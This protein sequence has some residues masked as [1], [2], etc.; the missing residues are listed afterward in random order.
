MKVCKRGA[1][2]LQIMHGGFVRPCEFMVS[3]DE[4]CNF[5]SLLESDLYEI[6]HGKP[7]EEL[8]E[9]I[10]NGKNFQYCRKD[11]CRNLASG[12][13]DFMTE[14]DSIPEY[15]WEL[16]LAYDTT[17]NY[18]CTSCIFHKYPR[19]NA[20]VLH[21]IEEKVRKALPYVKRLIA[22]GCGEVFASKSMMNLLAEWEPISPPE[23]CC[24][25]LQTNGSLFN[26]E[27]WKKI[28][29]IG[30]FYLDVEITIHSFHEKTYQ[31][32][33][34]TKLPIQNLIDNLHFV[35]KLRRE[36]IINRLEL[37]TVVQEQNFRE[38]P[39]FVRRC[40]DEFE[41]DLVR[42]RGF[43]PWGA[44]DKNVEWFFNVRNPKHPYYEEYLEVMR[45]PIFEHPKVLNWM[46]HSQSL[47]GEIPAKAN[48]DILRK[49][50]LAEHP[51]EKVKNYLKER[52]QQGVVIYGLC[53][54]ADIVANVFECAGIEV[55]GIMDKYTPRDSWRNKKIQRPTREVLQAMSDII[56]IAIANKAE[57]VEQDL[58]REGFKGDILKLE[59]LL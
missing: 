47:Q 53:E 55:V 12:N 30:R 16:N 6:Y 34:G 36:G 18:K 29:R 8:R 44:M 1:L 4:A 24:V 25:E 3:P 21:T 39:E 54:M 33:S 14:V 17:C 15:P 41:A 28:E 46:G 11:V 51:E 7:A 45:D 38:M 40:L 56:F 2:H 57:Y 50:H 43:E 22:N 52:N 9:L 35:K 10:A 37:A 58:R 20:E 31:Y 19:E 23:E 26:E 5:G 27:N 48:F 42:I 59:E 49:W 32:L 13:T